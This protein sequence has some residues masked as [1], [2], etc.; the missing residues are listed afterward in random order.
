MSKTKKNFIKKDKSSSGAFQILLVPVSIVLAGVIIAVSFLV[1][2]SA[3]ISETKSTIKTSVGE[4]LKN[5]GTTSTADSSADEVKPTIT[6]NQVKSLLDTDHIIFGNKDAK[7]VITEFSDPNCPYCHV[8]SGLN[9]TINNSIGAQ[10]K[11]VAEGGSYIA[12]VPQFKKLVDEGKAVYVWMYAKGHGSTDLGG[13]AM[14]CAQEKGKFWD[15]HDKLMTAAGYKLLNNDDQL[16]NGAT[17]KVTGDQIAEYTK[18]VVD[19]S[20]MK[21]CL[22]TQKYLPKLNRDVAVEASFGSQGT[23]GFYINTTNFSGAYN[24][25]AIEPTIKT[26]L[27]E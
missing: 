22:N 3:I 8:A 14:Y 11:L 19:Q 17:Y 6:A 2:A 10:F 18:D 5:A 25:T 9:P 13:Q 20:F 26:A 1:A 23:P 24:Y 15:V 16:F 12:P 21:D 7:V 27:G 4:A